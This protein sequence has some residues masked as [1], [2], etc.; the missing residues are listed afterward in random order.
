M[1]RLIEF[2]ALIAAFCSTGLKKENVLSFINAFSIFLNFKKLKSTLCNVCREADEKINLKAR[3]INDTTQMFKNLS[4]YL[5]CGFSVAWLYEFKQTLSFFCC[6]FSA[7]RSISGIYENST[8]FV[9]C[10]KKKVS[11]YTYNH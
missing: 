3:K 4:K 11:F 9:G 7:S 2:L 1:K 6:S 10:D 8:A 5:S